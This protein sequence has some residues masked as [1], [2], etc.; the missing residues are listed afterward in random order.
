MTGNIRFDSIRMF[1]HACA[2]ADCAYFCEREPNSI[3]I[4]TRWY[5]TPSVVNSAFACE[6][7]IKSLLI[8]NGM[9]LDEIKGHKLAVLWMTLEEKEQEITINIKSSINSIFNK[10][11]KF[12]Y[13]SLSNISDTFE[14]WRYIYEKNGG[15]I[16]INFLRIFRE[17]L[18]NACCEKYYN[19]SWNEYENEKL[20]QNG[21]ANV[22]N[23]ETVG[24]GDNI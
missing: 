3:I 14:Y 11:D 13:D 16:H 10:D 18:R 2:F 21:V 24:K 12:F 15:K 23:N 6:V 19:M 17:A 8:Y 9:S 7:F 5:T 20:V 22:S 1:R 4:P